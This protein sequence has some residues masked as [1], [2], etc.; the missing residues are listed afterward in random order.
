M[1]GLGNY[2]N[3][4]PRYQLWHPRTEEV[5]RPRTSSRC[6]GRGGPHFAVWHLFGL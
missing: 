2:R 3:R 6:N 4:G 1:A 5:E